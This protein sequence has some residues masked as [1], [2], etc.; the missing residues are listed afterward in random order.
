MKRPV[1]KRATVTG[2]GRGVGPELAEAHVPE[3]GTV[4]IADIDVTPAS[5]SATA[6]GPAAIAVE[7]DVTS[8]AGDE[9]MCS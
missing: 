2:A 1:G 8:T 6:P 4:A 9:W 5:S 3:G 7:I